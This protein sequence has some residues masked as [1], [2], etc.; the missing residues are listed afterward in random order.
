MKVFHYF[1]V[2]KLSE[3]TFDHINTELMH[4]HCMREIK[5]VP[6]CLY[7]VRLCVLIIFNSITCK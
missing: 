3:C 6:T 2:I 1:E 5:S 4:K 7:N